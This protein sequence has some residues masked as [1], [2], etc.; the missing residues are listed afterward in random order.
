MYGERKV[1]LTRRHT[2]ISAQAY[3]ALRKALPAIVWYKARTLKPFLKAAFREHPELLDGVDFKTPTKWEIT[4]TVVD[5]LLAGESRYRDTTL[6]LMLEVANMTRFPDLE[7]LE[8]SEQRIS[9]A[10]KAVAEMRRHT[11]GYEILQDE[12]ER[13]AA[14]HAVLEQQLASRRAFE[15]TLQTMHQDFLRLHQLDNPHSRGKAFE[16]F[17]LHLFGLFDLN[18]RGA[19][20]LEREQIDGAFTLDSDDYILEARW[21]KEKVT[22][23]QADAFARKVERKHKNA[24]G[25]IVSVT[26]FTKDAINEYASATPFLTMDGTDLFYVLDNR[27]R[28]DELLARK[29]RHASET[30]ECYFPVSM[31]LT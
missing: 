24:S 10:R 28:L 16:L 12:R 11:E 25:L 23:E 21:R 4:D 7:D 26:G 20:E 18:P 27:V 31:M 14:E 19:Y 9:I 22:R 30:G 1:T 3:Q 17:L 5:R 15:N 13:L 2:R 6:H 29:K 8:D